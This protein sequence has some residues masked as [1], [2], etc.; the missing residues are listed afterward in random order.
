MYTPGH[1]METLW[2]LVDHW[3]L[4]YLTAHCYGSFLLVPGCTIAQLV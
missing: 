1:I 3:Y 2:D 4:R